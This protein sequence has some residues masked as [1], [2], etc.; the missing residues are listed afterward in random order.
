MD[1]SQT[2]SGTESPT[3]CPI[4]LEYHSTDTAVLM[5]CAHKYDV[6]CIAVQLKMFGER[7]RQCP[8]CRAKIWAVKYAF[9]PDGMYK[10]HIPGKGYQDANPFLRDD[11]IVPPGA[12][13]QERRRKFELRNF[14][15]LQEIP[16][17]S[18]RQSDSMAVAFEHE[19][20]I[21]VNWNLTLAYRQRHGFRT[22][23]ILE[24]S[25]SLHTLK[26]P[27][28][29]FQ[30][31]KNFEP[32]KIATARGE[33]IKCLDNL[34]I[35]SFFS[36][37]KIQSPKYLVKCDDR[38]LRAAAM[39]SLTVQRKLGE[40]DISIRESVA[41]TE[42]Y[43]AELPGEEELRQDMVRGVGRRER[44]KEVMMVR[45]E[46]QGLFRLFEQVDTFEML[47]R[48]TTGILEEGREEDK[49][50]RYCD[51]RHRNGDCRLPNMD[52]LSLEERG[53]AK[54]EDGDEGMLTDSDTG[55]D[56]DTNTDTDTDTDTG[57]EEE[58]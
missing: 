28:K 36:K 9:P 23:C 50:C 8:M 13:E 5:P 18:Y 29:R 7:S 4:C 12:S 17:Q 37:V 2:L 57:I 26:T 15:T 32:E 31:G 30:D 39:R 47:D 10:I 35:K 44:E 25:L 48:G 16:L 24:R 38:G 51:V 41:I 22:S 45:Q 46:M 55:T 6:A 3:R 40:E 43:L 58:E 1:T 21:S 53:E 14:R 34:E 11:E 19:T 42:E 27:P 20:Y 54:E 52:G 56:T 33:I 49:E